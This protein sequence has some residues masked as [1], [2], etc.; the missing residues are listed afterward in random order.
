MT[1]SQGVNGL[2]LVTAGADTPG[3]TGPGGGREEQ[4]ARAPRGPDGE[5]QNE[6]SAIGGER[7]VGVQGDEDDVTDLE[8]ARIRRA[9]ADLAGE[10]ADRDRLQLSALTAASSRSRLGSWS[11]SRSW[12]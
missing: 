7:A 10:R 3:R 8:G 1:Y 9:R 4:N 5:A 2:A 6:S 12:W 11:S